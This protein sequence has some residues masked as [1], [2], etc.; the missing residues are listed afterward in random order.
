MLNLNDSGYHIILASQSPRRQFLLKETGLNFAVMVK[1]TNE[2]YPEHLE[3]E[4]IA[5][6]LSEHKA[7]A[8]N[9]KE[10]PNNTL[11]ITAD[12]I[13]WLDGES[14]GKPGSLDEAKHMLRK[15]S[16]RKHTVS[17]GVCFTTLYHTFSF[18][19]NTDVYFRELETHEID[20]Y[21]NA[22]KPLD[23]AGA[24]GIQE[25]IGYIGVD[26][27]DGSYFNVMGLPVQ[28]VY[29]ELKKFIELHPI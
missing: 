25:W 16:G 2:E 3:S 7:K 22:F 27:I 12:T 23:K 14:I 21:V 24:Y 29:V 1:S 8:F 17:T 10:L 15:L 4:Q 20:Y 6:Y 13:V 11:L 28:R 26:R 5:L 18:F 9:F 19:V